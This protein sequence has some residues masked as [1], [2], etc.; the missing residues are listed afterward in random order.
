MVTC[1]ALLKIWTAAVV[2]AALCGTGTDGEKLVSCCREVS[3]AEVKGPITGYW[4]QRFQ[5]PCVKAVIFETEKGLICSYHRLPW[6]RRKIKEFDM[7]RIS[8]SPSFSSTK[9]ITSTFMPS[10]TLHPS[11]TFLSS[12]PPSLSSSPPSLSSSPPSLS[13][14][15]P[16][17]SS[18]PP[19]LSSS[20]PSL[21]SSPP[22]SSP[23][24]V[25]SSVLSLLSSL[26]PAPRSSHTVLSSR[27]PL[28]SSPSYLLSTLLPATS[29]PQSLSSSPDVDSTK[30]APTQPS[31]SS[32]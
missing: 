11:P 1:G 17:L 2:M 28:S 30:D 12:S 16:S 22:L 4:L 24:S 29:S 25:I 8:K 9:S 18:S 15:P 5:A 14:S 13:S 31:P 6:V 23:P 3:T 20:P 21:S 10:T 32:Q 26:F 7:R 19:S 27:P